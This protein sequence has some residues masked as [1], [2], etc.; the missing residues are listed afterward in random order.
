M[1]RFAD[2]KWHVTSTFDDLQ[3]GRVDQAS[4]GEAQTIFGNLSDELIGFGQSHWIATFFIRRLGMDPVAAGRHL[5]TLADEL[6]A[7]NE[8]RDANYHAVGRVLR[9]QIT[10]SNAESAIISNRIC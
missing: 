2:I 7:R 9:F 1:S 6:G 8:D 4:F 3:T 10:S 5:G